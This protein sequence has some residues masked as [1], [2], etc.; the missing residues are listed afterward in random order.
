MSLHAARSSP[1]VTPL[2]L[3]QSN[4]LSSSTIAIDIAL[5]LEI[6][7]LMLLDDL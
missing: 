7:P 4:S 6:K 3:P 5:L 2:L 1:F